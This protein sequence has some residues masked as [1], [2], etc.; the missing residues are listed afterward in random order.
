MATKTRFERKTVGTSNPSESAEQ[1][2]GIGNRGLRRAAAELLVMAERYS[3][4]ADSMRR[5]A[6]LFQV[7]E[8]GEFAFA[9]GLVPAEDVRGPA[10]SRRP[11]EYTWSSS[12]SA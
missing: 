3:R 2:S 4:H 1:T 9:G 10:S 8:S 6:A 5:S 7:I 11:A 12:F